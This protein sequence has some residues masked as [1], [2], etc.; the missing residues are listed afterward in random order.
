M[1]GDFQVTACKMRVPLDVDANFNNLAIGEQQLSGIPEEYVPNKIIS[2]FP[3]NEFCC[4]CH[5]QFY[6]C[7]CFLTSK[8][9]F[10]SSCV[11]RW[12]LNC[13]R[14]MGKGINILSIY[15]ESGT[16]SLKAHHPAQKRFSFCEVPGWSSETSDFRSLC[17]MEPCHPVSVLVNL[18]FIWRLSWKHSIL[19][20]VTQ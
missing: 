8:D 19:H 14:I 1:P 15:C 5:V 16:V 12:D 2:L 13:K 18:A 11:I 10:K 7:F 3:I 6:L 20:I 17:S 9:G 4:L